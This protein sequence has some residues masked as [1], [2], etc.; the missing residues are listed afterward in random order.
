MRRERVREGLDGAENGRKD[1][2]MS[3]EDVAR[4]VKKDAERPRSDVTAGL[5]AVRFCVQ[6]RSDTS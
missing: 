6:T 1:G 4:G 2:L 3:V 5:Q